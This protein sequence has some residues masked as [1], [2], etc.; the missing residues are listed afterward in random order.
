LRDFLLG[1]FHFFA[2]FG[3]FGLL[4]LGVLDSSVLF[5]PLGN[6]LLVVAFSARKPDLFWYYALMAT[7]GSLLGCAITDYAARHLGEA[8]IEKFV[9]KDRVEKV[10]KKMERRGWLLLG[11]A[12]LMPPPFPFTVFLMA[13][14]AVQFSRLR[15]FSAIGVGRMVRFTALASLAVYYGKGIIWLAK[16]PEVQYVILGLAAISIVGSVFSIIRW[17]RSSRGGRKQPEYAHK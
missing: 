6:D 2:R 5:M 11:A 1:I 12:S 10:K 17:V 14:S 13:A 3:G 15:L 7:M 4:G 16:R 9:N 8:G